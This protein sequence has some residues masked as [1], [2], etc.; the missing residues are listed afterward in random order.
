MDARDRRR[1]PERRRVL[2]RLAVAGTIAVAITAGAALSGL[3]PSAGEVRDWGDDLGPAAPPLSVP[4][5]ALMNFAIPWPVLAAA[6]GLLFGVAAGTPL[7]LAGVTAAAA[8]QFTI[9]RRLAADHAGR[10][11]PERVRRFDEFLERRGTVAVIYTRILPGLPYGPVNYLGAITR[12]KLR[13]LV[14]GTLVGAV[15]KVFVYVALGGT[16]T[17]LGSTKA[18]AA[19]GLWAAVAVAGLVLGRRQLAAERARPEPHAP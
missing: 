14:A 11:V 1:D 10:L 6:E 16:L 18:K 8:L 2:I 13:D 7:A 9:A 19:L 12:L 5:F 3:T 17:D 15:P 4:L